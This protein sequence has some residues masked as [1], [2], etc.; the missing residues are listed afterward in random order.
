[1]LILTTLISI[2]VIVFS[3]IFSN[4]LADFYLKKGQENYKEKVSLHIKI[5]LPIFVTFF[6][7]NIF[8]GILIALGRQK[9]VTI[10]GISIIIF[11]GLVSGLIFIFGLNVELTGLFMIMFFLEAILLVSLIIVFLIHK[12]DVNYEH[13]SNT[14]SQ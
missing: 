1:M 4:L 8:Q 5:I 6:F 3:L 14:L 11:G 10:L 12:T 13:V 9:I 2:I 7:E